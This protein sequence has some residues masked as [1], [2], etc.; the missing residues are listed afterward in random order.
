MFHV[1]KSFTTTMTSWPWIN[2]VDV[3]IADPIPLLNG[4]DSRPSVKALIQDNRKVINEVKEN[5]QSNPLFN[6]DKH[7]D[8]WILRFLL[9]HK[10]NTK[11]AF[12]AAET[13]LAFRKEHKFDEQDIRSLSVGTGPGK[14]SQSEACQRYNKYCTEDA[15]RFV[16][17]DVTRG[18]IGCFRLAGVDQH[19][20][21][22]NVDKENWLPTYCYISE[23][24]FQWIDFVTRTT[25]RLTKS[26]RFLDMK[27]CG[28]SGISYEFVKRETDAM[29]V[30]E[31][32]YPQMLHSMFI[33]N[34]P[35]W[36]QIPWRVIRPLMP[37]RVVTKFDFIGR[38]KS[39]K[40]RK[41]L[42]QHVSEQNLPVR[43]GGKH[44][45]W[46][47]DFPPPVAG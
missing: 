16:V 33:C 24:T 41:R 12:K 25:G 27:G 17:P 29:G 30:M 43:F 44:E 15:C 23:W 34:S 5:L 35:V 47:V 18:V 28:L 11:V 9:S 13:T 42:F 40:E 20:M 38:P 4:Q 7:D 26:V 45:V 6:A 1:S 10:K 21:V 32:R 39:D 36:I 3:A 2:G 31:D 22:K 37:K 19:G 8:L 14:A 46:P